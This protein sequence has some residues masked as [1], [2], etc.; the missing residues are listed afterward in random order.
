M[1]PMSVPRRIV[2]GH[3]E[4]GKSV[5]LSDTPSPKTTDIGTAAFH[6]IWVTEAVPAEIP[7]GEPER[8]C[9]PSPP[10]NRSPPTARSEWA[11]LPAA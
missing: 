5:I 9:N 1:R 10:A 2:T 8:I 7:A 11:L 6:E 3:D 4:S